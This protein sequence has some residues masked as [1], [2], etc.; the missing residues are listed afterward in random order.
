MYSSLTSIL[1]FAATLSL[2]GALPIADAGALAITGGAVG[3]RAGPG[4]KEPLVNDIMYALGTPITV[5][6]QASYEDQLWDK[7]TDHCFVPDGN[8]NHASGK[9]K[10]CDGDEED[11]NVF[12]AVKAYEA[13]GDNP[14]KDDPP[15][16]DGNGGQ[17]GDD[18]GTLPG[19]DATQSGYARAIIR[20]AKK[21]KVGSQGCEAG[22]ATAWVEVSCSQRSCPAL[23]LNRARS[24]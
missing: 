11:P 13:D 19:L 14:P 9:F 4:P 21:D 7:T 12:G 2:S 24:L 16:D 23:P 8:V 6:C 3:C 1:A 18:Q 20:Q 17:G 10:P 15:N 22:I 5:I